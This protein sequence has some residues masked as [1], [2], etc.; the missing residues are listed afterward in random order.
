[1]VKKKIVPLMLKDDVTKVI[2]LILA[3]WAR[4]VHVLVWRYP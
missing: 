3:T 1:M 4:L 2:H